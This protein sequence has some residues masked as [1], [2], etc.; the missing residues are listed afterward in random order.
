[1]IIYIECN[2]KIYEV[3]TITTFDNSSALLRDAF[4][5][6]PKSYGETMIWELELMQGKSG[7]FRKEGILHCKRYSSKTQMI[8][9]H[10]NIVLK[11]IDGDTRFFNGDGFPGKD[12]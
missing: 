6:I 7:L 10:K 5:G 3:N 12:K 4:C 8:K 11:M 2:G 9:G 1:M